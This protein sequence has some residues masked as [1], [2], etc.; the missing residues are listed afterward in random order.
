MHDKT[1]LIVGN[2]AFPK[3]NAAGKRVLGLGYLFEELGYRV[4]YVG[5]QCNRYTN[6]ITDTKQVYENFTY[7]NF[8]GDRCLKN[9]CNVSNTFNDFRQIAIEVGIENIALIVI[10]GSPVLALWIQKVIIFGKKNHIPTV[11]DCVDWIEKSGFKSVIKNVVKYIDTNYMKRYLACKCDGVI[12]ISRY[13]YDYYKGKGCKTVLIPPVGKMESKGLQKNKKINIENIK[14]DCVRFVYA[15]SIPLVNSNN[16]E[17]WK[18]RV[19]LTFEIMSK[20]HEQGVNYIF[21]VFGIEKKQYIT[22]VP[23]HEA[24]LDKLELRVIFHGK[25]SNDI[26]CEYI[27][28]ADFT[29]L[30]RIV[31]KV[32][33]AGFPSK[34]SESLLLGTPVITNATSNISEYVKNG[35]NGL[36]IDFDTNKAVGEVLAYLVDRSQIINMKNKC[37]VECCFDICQFK[38]SM[39]KFIDSL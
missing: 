30:N 29:I 15:G 36:I 6:R 35:D 9:I 27:R 39:K 18:D 38:D 1:V 33:T 20:L 23:E 21:D 3:G 10:Y 2:F 7:Y 37:K 31:T 22:A 25:T 24:V 11:F 8:N 28:K 26:V 13:L 5:C 4:F 19:D 14:N 34:I 32:T 16:R 12:A 17:D